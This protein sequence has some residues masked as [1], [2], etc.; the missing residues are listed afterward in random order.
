MLKP[1]LDVLIVASEVAPFAKTGGLGDVTS[2]LAKSLRRLGHKPTIIIPCY[3]GIEKNFPCECVLRGIPTPISDRIES[4]N[5]FRTFIEP[6]IPVFLLDKPGYFDRE[7][8]YGST[9][10][11]DYRDNSE[12]FI[13]FSRSIPELISHL[14]LTPD[15]VHCHD[16]QAALVPLYLRL[17]KDSVHSFSTPHTVFTFHDLS[18]QGIFWCYDMQYT[19][20][21][22]DYFR[23]DRLEFYGDL[24][25]LKAG[26]LFSDALTTVS[27]SYCRAVQ[28]PA[29]GQGLDGLLRSR[30]ARLF[31]IINGIDY[32]QW[33]PQTDSL[34]PARFSLDNPAGKVQCKSSLIEKC[35]F[36]PN[37]ERPLAG[38]VSRLN[39]PKG[40][41][42]L[43]RAIPELL[44][45]DMYLCVLGV[46]DSSIEDSLRTLHDRYPDRFAFFNQVDEALAH[47]IIAG[48]DFFLMPSRFEPGGMNQFQ[49]MRY[50]TIP[51]ACA[52]FGLDETIED[53]DERT[54][55]GT[56]IK[57][58]NSSQGELLQAVDRAIR[59]FRNSTHWHDM[60]L[61]CMLRDASSLIC[62]TRYSVI[63]SDLLGSLQ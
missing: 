30:S 29:Y 5:V 8:L 37:N 62:A 10:S 61:N 56:G 43:V 14:G 38:V 52:T 35:G 45:R 44:S 31:G 42:T 13:Y 49:C 51:I 57:F 36:F 20:L 6:D 18:Y 27:E 25:L 12:R 53:Y 3:R 11:G 22:W 59:L 19:G 46:G 63:Y 1:N 28:T 41:D 33:N 54:H 34:I 60:T 23:P 24:N 9:R 7:D 55:R 17:K 40:M 48:S 32:T 50:A 58:S 2:N 15:I 26:I 16:W 21:S 39:I 47:E 4:A